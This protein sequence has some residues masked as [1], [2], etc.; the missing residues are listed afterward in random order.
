[1]TMSIVLPVTPCQVTPP[2]LPPAHVVVQGGCSLIPVMQNGL[3][4]VEPL[5][6]A[7]TPLRFA[8]V[9]PGVPAAT[10]LRF[11][12]VLRVVRAATGPRVVV[13]PDTVPPAPPAPPPSPEPAFPLLAV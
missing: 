11:A 2:L 10:P 9:L 7:A 3:P 8:T 1:M 13:V 12:P 6:G 5:A 4:V